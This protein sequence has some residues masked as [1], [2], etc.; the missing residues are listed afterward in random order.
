MCGGRRR[1]ESQLKQREQSTSSPWW[2]CSGPQGIGWC[3]PH[4]EGGSYSVYQLN[5]HL[6]QKHPQS[7]TAMFY[8]LSG[9]PLASSSWHIKLTITLTSTWGQPG[10]CKAGLA[11]DPWLRSV[12][13][14]TLDIGGLG[15]SSAEK[16]PSCH[17]GSCYVGRVDTSRDGVLVR[18]E[19]S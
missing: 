10:A 17:I 13:P 4:W 14:L 8:Q 5:A 7:H 2:F 15:V 6:F 9:H 1:G 12:C 3:H 19:S 11:N 18:G 16:E